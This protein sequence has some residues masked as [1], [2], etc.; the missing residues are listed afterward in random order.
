VK[1]RLFSDV[2]LIISNL[3]EKRDLD[4]VSML[5]NWEKEGISVQRE[6]R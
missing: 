4:T 3:R 5:R 1:E 2:G 6:W